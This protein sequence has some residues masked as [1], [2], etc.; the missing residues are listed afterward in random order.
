M[1]PIT[2]MGI[3]MDKERQSIKAQLRYFLLQLEEKEKRR[4][5]QEKEEEEE[6]D[7]RESHE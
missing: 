4:K 1:K 5:I 7:E 3:S 2:Y 6:K